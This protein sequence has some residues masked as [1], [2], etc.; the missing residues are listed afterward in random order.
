MNSA[1]TLIK[2]AALGVALGS[3]A[4]LAVNFLTARFLVLYPAR[5][6]NE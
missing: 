4:G 5:S 2:P 6:P 1:N 3:I